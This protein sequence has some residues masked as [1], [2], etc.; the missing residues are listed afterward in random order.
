MEELKRCSKCK[1]PK[2]LSE[3]HKRKGSKDGH[4]HY[5]KECGNGNHRLKYN[6][7]MEYKERMKRKTIKRSYN[8]SDIELNKLYLIKNCQICGS[9]LTKKRRTYI[10]HNHKTG[11]VRGLLC[12]KCNIL[13]GA[14]ND[15]IDILN[16]AISYLKNNG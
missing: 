13:L 8:I 7:D 14:C 2:P 11:S 16:S 15:N 3:F 10:D 1:T 12:P 9:E 5:C 6:T 4:D